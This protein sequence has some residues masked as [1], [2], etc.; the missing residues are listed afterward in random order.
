MLF[1]I[2]LAQ[3]PLASVLFYPFDETQRDNQPEKL[4][5][6]TTGLGP[7]LKSET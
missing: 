4:G 2:R 3:P 5:R 1:G 6:E 7:D